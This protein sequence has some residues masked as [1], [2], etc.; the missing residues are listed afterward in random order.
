MSSTDFILP[1]PRRGSFIKGQVSQ[2][3]SLCPFRASIFILSTEMCMSSL[4]LGCFCYLAGPVVLDGQG[5]SHVFP[6]IF[7]SHCSL[8]LEGRGEPVVGC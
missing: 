6:D 8:H 1:S 3:M 5:K 2:Q 7:L 4:L